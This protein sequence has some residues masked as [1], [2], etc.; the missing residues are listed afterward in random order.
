M[1]NILVEAIRGGDIYLV[2][3]LLSPAII[4][5]PLYTGISPLGLAIACNKKDVVKLLLDQGARVDFPD[6]YGVPP[7]L[8]AFEN[9]WGTPEYIEIVTL[10]LERSAKINARHPEHGATVLHQAIDHYHLDAIGFL[11]SSGA[12]PDALDHYHRTP[13]FKAVD[14][15]CQA[16]E[17]E[18]GRWRGSMGC[19]SGTPRRILQLLIAKG[20]SRPTPN[21]DGQSPLEQARRRN[22]PE[23]AALLGDSSKVAPASRPAP[24]ELV[25]DAA[26]QQDQEPSQLA[27]SFKSSHL[28][29]SSA[30]AV[31][32]L[33]EGALRVLPKI[34]RN[35]IEAEFNSI[36]R[37]WKSAGRL[38]VGNEDMLRPLI[39][40]TMNR[41]E[42]RSE[43]DGYKVE[44]YGDGA[45]INTVTTDPLSV[46]IIR[47]WKGEACLFLGGNIK[48]KTTA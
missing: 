14:A 35:L 31:Q 23:T 43:I 41:L 45:Q 47:I 37:S 20:A 11:L 10:L 8:Y 30:D 22:C 25:R 21:R 48:F 46:V 12:D 5:S 42:A 27:S 33:F 39:L 13:F 7:I 24:S 19:P 9:N 28:I 34:E 17:L 38:I 44:V 1:S 26:K 6:R 32:E 3:Q 29:R 4:N 16:E 18:L 15:C 2:K 36:S 40:A